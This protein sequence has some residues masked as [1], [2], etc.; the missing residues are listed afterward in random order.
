ML[1]FGD[2]ATCKTQFVCFYRRHSIVL[3]GGLWR[4]CDRGTVGFPHGICH[5]L[6]PPSQGD[7]AHFYFCDG[8]PRLPERRDLPHVW[9]PSVSTN[10]KNSPLKNWHPSIFTFPAVMIKK[11]ASRPN[12]L[13]FYDTIKMERRKFY[14]ARQDHVLRNHDEKLR[15]GQHLAQITHDGQVRHEDAELVVRDG[16]FHVPRRGHRQ[17]RSLV[18]H[19]VRPAHGA[20][21]LRLQIHRSVLN[22]FALPSLV[23]LSTEI[24]G[25]TTHREITAARSKLG[26]TRTLWNK[27]A[28]TGVA[29]GLIIGGHFSHSSN[30]FLPVTREK[31]AGCEREDELVYLHFLGVH[32]WRPSNLSPDNVTMHQ[33]SHVHGAGAEFSNSMMITMDNNLC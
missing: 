6:H 25:A 17:Q 26:Q 21:L 24:V 12:F 33:F 3:R 29:R 20:L 8:L 16:Y 32:T 23:S 28:W 19:V 13:T 10:S 15:G 5:S 30:L 27:C 14:C 2:T 9:H 18:E 11:N 7:R 4:D 22:L 1:F 31:D